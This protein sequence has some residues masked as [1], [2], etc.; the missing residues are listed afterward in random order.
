MSAPWEGILNKI[1]DY[2][3]EIPIGYKTGMRVPGLIYAS[4]ALLSHIWEETKRWGVVVALIVD[5]V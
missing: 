4:E 5:I 1:D 3:W 2:R